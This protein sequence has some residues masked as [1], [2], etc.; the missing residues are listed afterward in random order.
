VLTESGPGSVPKG[1]QEEPDLVEHVRVGDVEV[2]PDLAHI[3]RVFCELFKGSVF[4]SI[5]GLGIIVQ[6]FQSVE[7][8]LENKKNGCI[9]SGSCFAGP[10]QRPEY[11]T[12]APAAPQPSFGTAT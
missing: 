3:S 11:R 12:G 2:V 8:E 7:N 9:H 4:F 1:K 6:P 10:G 5:L